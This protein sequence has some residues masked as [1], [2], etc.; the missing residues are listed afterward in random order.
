MNVHPL[1]EAPG[2]EG[3]PSL[4]SPT[5]WIVWVVHHIRPDH[6]VPAVGCTDIL[7]LPA[8]ARWGV[9]LVPCSSP[10]EAAWPDPCALAI[11][12]TMPADPGLR[13]RWAE[14][15]ARS[16]QAVL[17]ISPGPAGREEGIPGPELDVLARHRFLPDP[18]APPELVR[19]GLFL[20][21]RFDGDLHQ[22]LL[23]MGWTLLRERAEMGALREMLQ[24][25]D[26]RYAQAVHQLWRLEE[27]AATWRE[28]ERTLEERLQEMARRWQALEQSP[29]YAVL[30]GLQR[31]R[32]RFLPSGSRR[33]RLGAMVAGWLR[34]VQE[35]GARGLVH[36][37]RGEV[38]WRAQA[39]GRRLAPGH[40]RGPVQIPS[41]P[42][43]PPVSPH[44]APVDIVVCVHNALEEVRRCLASVEQHTAPPYRLILVDDGSAP[45]TRDFLAEFARE[46]EHVVLLRHEEPLGYTRAANRG[47]RRTDAA[48]VLLLNSD[49]AV[50]PGWLDRLVACAESHPRIGLVGPLSNTASW[51]SVPRVSLGDDWADNPLPNGLDLDT[52]SQALGAHASRLYPAMPFL[53]GFCLLIRRD[54]LDQVGLFDE[55]HFPQ[56]YGEENDYALR[57]RAAG[58]RLA[59]ADDTFVYHAQSRSYDHRRR[60]ELSAHADRVL[61]QLHPP[62]AI[63]R[64]VAYCREGLVLEGIRARVAALPSRLERLH[65]GRR[66]FAGRRVLFLLPADA[67]GGGANVVLT[68]ARAMASMGVEVAIFN[69]ETKRP[70]FLQGYPDLELPVLFGRP[71]DVPLLAPGYDAV[72][73]TWFE[74]L[75]WLRPLQGQE[76]SLGYYIQDVEAYFFPRGSP[77]QGRALASYTAVPGIRCFTKTAWNRAELQRL[78]GIRPAVVGPS[79]DLQRF[80]PRDDAWEA[81][82]PALRL[83]AMI[84]PSSPR[85]GPAITMRVLRRV[86]RRYGS[87]VQITLFGVDPADPGFAALPQDFDWRLAGVIPPPQVAW[88]LGHTDIFVDF[89]TYQAMGLTGLEAMAAGAAVIVPACGGATSYARHGENALVVDTRSE[90]SCY[91]ALCRL[92]EERALRE[93]IRRRAV[94]D[95]CRH[96]PEHAA[97]RILE[98]LFGP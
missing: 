83:A 13:V 66:R 90:E 64:G 37:L 60:R 5:R 75:D 89:S 94:W 1:P 9:H 88:L 2:G 35:R 67:P 19:E 16:T 84:R 38:H 96:A 93:Q 39:L 61:R 27:R 8:L 79:V 21:R 12:A 74:S 92:I 76:R 87:R 30:V 42:Q 55:L 95:V 86:A 11:L 71:E 47:L 54:V 23:E 46:R 50:T 40:R 53:N 73:A 80:C 6:P 72:V 52:W 20:L 17:L 29:G 44:T 91:R 24:E 65:Q 69:L 32:A 18:L 45:P 85:R 4:A 82:G 97:Y 28:R 51:Q 34:I 26:H 43:R 78:V 33:E 98:V 63:E 62:E 70:G 22:V 57:A 59:L 41:I 15:L 14:H 58:W 3:D 31:A 81:D 25:G 49:T 56:G 48:F 36:H 77:E 7:D 68:E 10:L